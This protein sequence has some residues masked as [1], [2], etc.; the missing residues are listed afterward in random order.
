[1]ILAASFPA[2][3][4]HP[5]VWLLVAGVAALGFY[6]VR[7]I[8]PKVVA[9]G[10]PVVSRAQVLWFWGA[11]ALLWVSSD[12]PIHDVGEEYLYTVHMAQHFLLTMV[13]APM[14]LLATP[15]WLAELVVTD[16]GWVWTWLR[17]LAAPVVATLVFNGVTILTHWQPVVNRSVEDG[18]FHYGVHL[19]VVA[20][21]ILM[22]IPVCGPWPQLRMKSVPGTLVY[23]FLQSIVPTVPSAWLAIAG[24]A[25]Y[26]SYD[27]DNHLFG[28][29]TV[30]DQQAAG[31]FMK[32][33]T[34]GWL[35]TIIIVLFFRWAF[36]LGRAE[37]DAR[38]L[39]A[40]EV[41][42]LEALRSGDD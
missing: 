41:A 42:A 38:V 18:P 10:E 21:A 2:W 11:V 29:T 17:R 36:A 30:Q 7:V 6:A 16:G 24:D 12:W 14:F 5:E 32:V 25:I 3:Q 15:R 4:P 9:A 33:V 23:L 40:D 20:T 39:T 1:M 28:V 27:H 26:S 22:W 34:G 13:L 19:I 31:V 8:G 35:W 37:R